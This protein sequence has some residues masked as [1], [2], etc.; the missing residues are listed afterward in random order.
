M[1]KK[2]RQASTLVSYFF[3]IT[4]KRRNMPRKSLRR[5]RSSKKAKRRPKSKKIRGGVTRKL[6]TRRKVSDLT[7]EIGLG[8]GGSLNTRIKEFVRPALTN[9][10]IH[11]AVQDY[12]NGGARKRRIVEKYGEISN[13]DT[14]RVTDMFCMFQFAHSFN[15]PLNNWNVSNVTNMREM[16]YGAE[17]FN[18]P[19]NKWD[20]TCPM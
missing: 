12:L 11:A 3:L 5:R 4:S 14:S 18:Q 2:S 10:S 1:R 16:F 13:W 7:H 17:S 8:Q 15:Q 19:L 6:L 9:Q 20:G